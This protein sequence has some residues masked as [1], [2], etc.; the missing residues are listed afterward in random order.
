VEVSDISVKVIDQF[1]SF[2]YC[3]H[4]KDKRENGKTEPDWVGMLPGYGR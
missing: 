3:G 1:L 4:F 2:L